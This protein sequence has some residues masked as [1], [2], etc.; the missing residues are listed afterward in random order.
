MTARMAFLLW[1][2]FRFRASQEMAIHAATTT[3]EI[4]NVLIKIENLASLTCRNISKHKKEFLTMKKSEINTAQKLRI[5]AIR[6]KS[7]ITTGTDNSTV[8]GGAEQGSMDMW[9][10]P[11]ISYLCPTYAIIC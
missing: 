11:L 3:P 9:P 6:I 8:R 4:W 5:D 7:F 1:R 10:C 2:N